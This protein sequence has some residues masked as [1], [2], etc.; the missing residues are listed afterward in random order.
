MRGREKDAARSVDGSE[1]ALD[2]EHGRTCERAAARAAR[3]AAL[4]RAPAA[5]ASCAASAL[6]AK[7]QVP[8]W[9]RTTAPPRP[10]ACR[11]R[12]GGGQG[13]CV[14]CPGCGQQQGRHKPS[15]P[16]RQTA[17]PRLACRGEQASR[18]AATATGYCLPPISSV[19]SPPQRAD[20]TLFR[21]L[22]GG[23]FRGGGEGSGGEGGGRGAGA[24]PVCRLASP[25]R[26][27]HAPTPCTHLNVDSYWPSRMVAS[28]T[29]EGLTPNSRPCPSVWV[30]P[31][32]RMF[33][34]LA[35]L[36]TVLSP[37]GG[38]G[39]CRGWR[40]GVDHPARSCNRSSQHNSPQQAASER[41]HHCG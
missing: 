40:R 3:P 7:L 2:Q 38:E 17:S 33:L 41:A 9:M 5:P 12:G 22:W 11:A 15:S 6:S 24:G 35:G 28:Y 30:A 39:E 8:R 1:L 18:G 27:L 20:M 14:Q 29:A 10:L 4:R 13:Q 37:A 23:G 32:L 34:A 16:A 21:G 25:G 19:M 26:P 36:V 31:T